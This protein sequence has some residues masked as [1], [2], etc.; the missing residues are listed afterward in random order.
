MGWLA[1]VPLRD[2][3]QPLGPHDEV[4]IEQAVRVERTTAATRT[5]GVF[6]KGSVE[7]VLRECPPLEQDRHQ[8]NPS[9]ARGSGARR[10][11]ARTP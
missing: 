1:K 2:D 5:R 9:K 8:P 4:S 10:L 11:R 7:W 3:V 6:I